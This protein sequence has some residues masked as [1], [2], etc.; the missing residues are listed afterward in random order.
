[1]PVG[2]EPGPVEKGLPETSVIEEELTEK[3][4]TVP[5]AGQE[6]G[7]VGTVPVTGGEVVTTTALVLRDVDE[8][9]VGGDGEIGGK[10]LHGEIIGSSDCEWG[11]QRAE[12]MGTGVDGVDDEGAGAG[13]Q[14]GKGGLAGR[15]GCVV[16]EH[17]E[18]GAGGIESDGDG[19]GAGCVD[20]LQRIQ[21]AVGADRELDDGVV[22]VIGDEEIQAV[23]R[24]HLI[25]RIA[26]A[27][28][29][30]GVGDLE[31]SPGFGV[32]LVDIDLAGTLEVAGDVEKVD[33]V[34]GAAGEDQQR[35]SRGGRGGQE[36][37]AKLPELHIPK[38]CAH[39]SVLEL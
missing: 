6:A 16:I 31:K 15:G 4:E 12:A 39:Q 30:R 19:F 21:L 14:I 1:M 29:I 26:A 28:G 9:A 25:D 8:V 7:R 32:D 17:I 20:G 23:G 37:R 5:E 10:A 22:V 13:I 11:A 35:Q 2:S 38:S 3:A 36:P 18:G 27:G 24:C 33:G 34:A